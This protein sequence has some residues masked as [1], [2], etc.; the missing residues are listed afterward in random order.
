MSVE[1]TKIE[2][3]TEEKVT[4]TEETEKAKLLKKLVQRTITLTD[5]WSKDEFGSYG[6][7]FEIL[8]S[9]NEFIGELKNKTQVDKIELALDA[10]QEF[11]RTYALKYRDQLSDK[12]R[13]VLDFIITEGG[14]DILSGATNFIQRIVQKIDTNKDG[15]I[16]KQECNAYCRKLF[17]CASIP[18][19]EIDKEIAKDN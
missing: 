12:G 3:T 13:E 18:Q 17:C 8:N 14:R 15:R 19:E 5:S 9:I 6:A 7:W 2:T 11:A 4:T 10:A 16:S 1:E